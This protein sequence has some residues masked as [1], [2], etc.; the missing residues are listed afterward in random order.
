MI[1]FLSFGE[2]GSAEESDP[3]ERL[4]REDRDAYGNAPA[5]DTPES[6]DTPEDVHEAD[7]LVITGSNISESPEAQPR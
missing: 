1:A 6:S 4:A 5:T 7:R 3:Q 2:I